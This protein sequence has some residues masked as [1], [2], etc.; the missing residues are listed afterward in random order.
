MKT[1]S[2][3][4]HYI[5]KFLTKGFTNSSGSL[6]IYDKVKDELIRTPRSP[7]SVFFEIDRNTVHVKDEQFS[8]LIE[9]TLYQVHDNSSSEV[10]GAFQTKT[11]NENLLNYSNQGVF[12]FFLINLFWRIP[13]TDFAVNDLINRAEIKSVGVDPEILR[14]DETFKK[15][16]RAG[17]FMNTINQMKWNQPSPDYYVSLKEMPYELFLIGDNPILFRSLPHTFTDLVELDYFFA[18]SSKRIYRSS[19]K[20][21]EAFTF[22]K[23]LHYNTLIIDQSVKY[24][25]SGNLDFLKE[26]IEYYKVHKSLNL[27]FSIRES[28][29]ECK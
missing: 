15:L 13:Y 25:C 8:S 2:S 20:E 12:Q 23:A 5:P 3:R 27:M 18:V 22:Q 26:S 6:Y 19:I 7:K 11:I 28:L 1:N 24:I 4:Y 9:D 16:Q 29:F 21:L 10:I 17:L 14:D